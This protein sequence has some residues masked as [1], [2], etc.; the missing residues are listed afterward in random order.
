MA[1]VIALSLMAMPAMADGG[2]KVALDGKMLTFDVPPQ[3]INERTMVP[4]RT[5]FEALG[6][7]VEW[8]QETQTVTSQKGNT[9]V[10]LTINNPVMY[11]NDVAKEL[12][13]PA[14][15]IDERT[16]VPA[17][18][19]SEAYGLYV[20]W[21]QETQTVVITTK[22]PSVLAAT[23]GSAYVL[24]VFDSLLKNDVIRKGTYDAKAETYS[25]ALPIDNSLSKIVY[26]IKADSIAFSKVNREQIGGKDYDVNQTICIDRDKDELRAEAMIEGYYGKPKMSMKYTDGK[27]VRT[28]DTFTGQLKNDMYDLLMK[29]IDLFASYLPSITDVKLSDFGIGNI[30]TT[31][32]NAP[33]VQGG[34]VAPDAAHVL[35]VYDILLKNDI[36]RK[37]TLDFNALT[38]YINVPNG[39]C[40]ITYDIREDIVKFTNVDSKNG[41]DVNHTICIDRDEEEIW[42]QVIDKSSYSNPEMTL[43][44]TEK[45]WKV[46]KSTFTTDQNEAAYDMIMAN[47]KSVDSYLPSY[48]D[49][50]F[51]NFGIK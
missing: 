15:I 3:I 37:G 6:A 19:I 32:V 27:W 11:V 41:Y 28:V 21:I 22:E 24:K 50:R 38:Y 10:S 20:G 29:D 35:R 39:N 48:T 13:T 16:L 46:G 26:D 42:A 34:V 51:A 33:Q 36:I 18:A 23:P 12:D 49:V 43:E 8:N 25:I 2:I 40:T 5:I 31:E 9:R 30:T 4:V 17:R 7:K 14:M 1:T 44:F 47:I 45:R